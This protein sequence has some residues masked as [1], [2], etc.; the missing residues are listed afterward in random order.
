MKK[1]RIFTFNNL[2]TFLYKGLQEFIFKV[3]TYVFIIT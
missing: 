2:M 3:A 1:G